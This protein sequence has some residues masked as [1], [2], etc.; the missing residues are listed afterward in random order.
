MIFIPVTY[1][2][3]FEECVEE[4]AVLSFLLH[5]CTVAVVVNM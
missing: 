2:T 3:E 1:Y 4:I 5:I